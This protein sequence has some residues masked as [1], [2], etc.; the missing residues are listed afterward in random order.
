MSV[1]IDV[2]D[3]EKKKSKPPEPPLPRS[4]TIVDIFMKK[5]FPLREAQLLATVLQEKYNI[6]LPHEMK[7]SEEEL[8][9]VVRLLAE[10]LRVNQIEPPG[11]SSASLE[12]PELDIR[13]ALTGSTGSDAKIQTRVHNFLHYEPHPQAADPYSDVPLDKLENCD[14]CGI[15]AAYWICDECKGRNGAATYCT[16]CKD[17]LHQFPKD[18]HAKSIHGVEVCV[19]CSKAGELYC[20]EEQKFFC[21]ACAPQLHVNPLKSDHKLKRLRLKREAEEKKTTYF[22]DDYPLHQKEESDEA[23]KLITVIV[24]FFNEESR[25]LYRTLYSLCQQNNQLALQGNFELHVLL[26][27]DGWWKASKSMKKYL[28][29]MFPEE[30]ESPWSKRIAQIVPGQEKD[31]VETFVLQ[32]LVEG[33]NHGVQ[34]VDVSNPPKDEDDV[35][36]ARE[37]KSTLGAEPLA[38][39]R[40]SKSCFRE[41][42]SIFRRFIIM[43]LILATFVAFAVSAYV[44]VVEDEEGVPWSPILW[45]SLASFAFLALCGCCLN[46]SAQPKK[47]NS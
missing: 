6:R 34:T 16:K 14:E 27:S 46:L 39:A 26:V 45:S 13:A 8:N 38:N 7:F 24:P 12:K 23:K 37:R 2:E 28:T 35:P 33:T 18:K 47:E 32:R 15:A 36:I 17:V 41:C 44:I 4:T 22:Y 1:F 30:K 9:A 31:S 42:L 29:Q 5:D 10:T 25:E 20:E 19:N 11:S 3:D 40:E 21:A 43:T